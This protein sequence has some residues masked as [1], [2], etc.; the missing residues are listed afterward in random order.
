MISASKVSEAASTVSKSSRS[1]FLSGRILLRSKSP[2]NAAPHC[3]TR[4]IAKTAYGLSIIWFKDEAGCRDHDKGRD[5][6]ARS[7]PNR[8]NQVFDL[9]Q[10]SRQYTDYYRRFSFALVSSKSSFSEYLQGVARLPKI[11][12]GRLFEPQRGMI[13]QV[14]GTSG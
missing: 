7:S 2:M 4:G 13:C 1:S 10:L 11:S 9:S 5:F 14:A 8:M 6:N 3:V 12:G